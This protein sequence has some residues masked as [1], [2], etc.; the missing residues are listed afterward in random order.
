[1]AACTASDADTGQPYW[2][3]P[4]GGPVWGSTLVADGKVYVGTLRRS[5][6]VLAAGKEL[7]VINRIAMPD[8]ILSSPAAANGTLYMAT[9]RELYALCELEPQ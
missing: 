6:W 9:F 1:M 5:L 2:V 4:I 8:S 7:K 3:H